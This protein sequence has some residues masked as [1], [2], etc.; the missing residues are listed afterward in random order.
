M[1][2]LN[3]ILLAVDAPERSAELYSGLLGVAPVELSPTFAL[4][5]TAN[6]V[7]VGLWAKA[8]MQPTP[9]RPGGVEVSFSHADKAGVLK[10]YEAWTGLGLEVVQAPTEMDFGFTF[11]VVD[12][13]GH[14]L[15]AFALSDNP[16]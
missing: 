12:P 13:D 4:F 8:D 5:V 1:P 3:Y 9:R 14:R 7:K 15:R 2:T 16:R 11:V 6:G 10:T